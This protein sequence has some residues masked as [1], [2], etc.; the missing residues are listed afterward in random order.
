[1]EGLRVG[2]MREGEASRDE[3]V[4]GALSTMFVAEELGEKLDFASLHSCEFEVKGM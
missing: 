2:R 3:G 1:M 4:G